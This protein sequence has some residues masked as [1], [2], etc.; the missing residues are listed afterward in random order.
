MF[1][2]THTVDTDNIVT[3]TTQ[4]TQNTSLLFR[5][6]CQLF[7]FKIH[8]QKSVLKLQLNFGEQAFLILYIFLKFYHQIPIVTF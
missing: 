7:H 4:Y 1:F 3:K 2:L 6:F 8:L 5:S